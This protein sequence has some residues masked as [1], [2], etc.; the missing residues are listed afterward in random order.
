M[1]LLNRDY[2][3]RWSSEIHHELYF[4]RLLKIKKNIYI[5]TKEEYNRCRQSECEKSVLGDAVAY[6]IKIRNVHCQHIVYGKKND[7]ILALLTKRTLNKLFKYCNVANNITQPMNIATTGYY[8]IMG[9]H[10]SLTK[11]HNM[12]SAPKC[13]LLRTYRFIL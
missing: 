2:L 6:M 5:Y 3:Y 4:I 8:L 12:E 9:I 13:D 11:N 7:Q 1:Y 10:I